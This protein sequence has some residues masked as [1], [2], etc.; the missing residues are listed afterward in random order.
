LLQRKYSLEDAPHGPKDA[1]S[2]WVEGGN[3][4]QL[5][6]DWRHYNGVLCGKLVYKLH[7]SNT[8][9]VTL[10]FKYVRLNNMLISYPCL[11]LIVILIYFLSCLL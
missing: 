5:C 2:E 3:N 7:F 9:N 1:V 4:K 11:T 10:V 6:C 8:W